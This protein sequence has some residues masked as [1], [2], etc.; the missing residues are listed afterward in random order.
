M[1][2]KKS[3][4]R[5]S[6]KQ[7]LL[8]RNLQFEETELDEALVKYNYFNLING[9]ES[10][11]LSSQNPKYFNKVT[12]DDFIAIYKFNKN[13]SA[14]ILDLLN[15]I[16]S[17]L[18]NSVSYH[19]TQA[20]C[21]M[22][23]DTM[24]YTL[25]SNYTD[26]QTGTYSQHYPFVNYQNKKIYNEFDKFILFKE[27][28]LKI[29]VERN[30]HNNHQFYS[31]P[32]YHPSNTGVSIYSEHP[33]VAVPFWV[34]IETMTLGQVLRLLH[35]LEDNVLKEV[36]AD[37][38][39]TLFHR[40]EFLNMFDIITSLRNCCAHGRL[41]YRYQSP[42]SVKLNM[43]LVSLF[44]L[45]PSETGLQPSVLSL[46]DALKI[47]NYFESTKPLK[48]HINSI[49]YRNNKHFKSPDFDLNTRLLTKMGEPSL[50]E[51]KKFIFTESK[52]IFK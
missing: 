10:I 19:F 35:Y 1:A 9:I 45:T 20:H 23:N 7:K 43:G 11:L 31:D 30:D 50:K 46:F 37:F 17:K 27:N 4:D 51:W 16:E 2:I 41:V 21:Q 26:P 14:A 44:Q 38:N 34:A 33:N 15:N 6:L 42:K 25:S 18:K 29:L 52:F 13:L 24:N 3:E 12:L 32:S 36:M 39:M 47:V 49:I 8:D 48:K 28:Y 22:I 40:N 5:N